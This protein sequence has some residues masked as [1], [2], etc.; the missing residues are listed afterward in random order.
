VGVVRRTGERDHRRILSAGWREPPIAIHI[1]GEQFL[2][3]SGRKFEL[4]S[5][6]YENNFSPTLAY[7]SHW[8]SIVPLGV[9]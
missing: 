1:Q 6:T 3:G 5:Q 7:I 8:K 4:F 9:V 2:V